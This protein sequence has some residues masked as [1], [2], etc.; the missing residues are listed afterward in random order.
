MRRFLFS[1]L[2]LLGTLGLAQPAKNDKPGVILRVEGEIQPASAELLKNRLN[3]PIP[4]V[5]R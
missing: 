1:L 4:K 5:V 2:L 3:K